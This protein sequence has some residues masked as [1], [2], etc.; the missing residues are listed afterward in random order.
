MDDTGI[1]ASLSALE[2]DAAARQ[3]DLDDGIA[4]LRADRGA[5]SA[6]D[7][8]DPEGSTLSAEWSRLVGLR[9]A[10]ARERADLAAAL[11]RWD[12]GTY[13]V[14]ADCGAAIPRERLAA[15]PMATRCVACAARAGE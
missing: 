5:E 15:R 7:E 1:H 9:D 2:A 8:H 10:V 4:Q 12:A 13:G 3:A 11:A 14:C 6:D